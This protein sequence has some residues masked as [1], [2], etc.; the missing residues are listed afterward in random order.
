MDDPR[1]W[2]A[3]SFA[4]FVALVY[5]KLS[6]FA[7]RALDDRSAQIQHELDEARRLREAAESVLKEYQIK[8]AEYLQEAEQMLESARTDA[9]AMRAYAEKELEAQLEARTRQAMERIAQEEGQAVS[10]VRDHVV[11]IALAAARALIADHV[12]KMPQE[13]LVK[14]ALSDIERKIH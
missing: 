7:C 13:E 12:S 8:Q 3:A 4:I 11:D 5:R 14:L 10:E 9:N 1:L 6:R 2:V